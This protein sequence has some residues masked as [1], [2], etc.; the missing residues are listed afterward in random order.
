MV[1]TSLL[2]A[3]ELNLDRRQSTPNATSIHNSYYYL[4]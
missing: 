4:R 2:H 3:T 1:T